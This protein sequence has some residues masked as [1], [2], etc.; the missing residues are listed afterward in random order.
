[1]YDDVNSCKFFPSGDAIITASDSPY[2][3]L[4]DVSTAQRIQKYGF[5]NDG[6]CSSVDMARETYLID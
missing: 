6:T 3:T 4:Y 5:G 1:M 2:V